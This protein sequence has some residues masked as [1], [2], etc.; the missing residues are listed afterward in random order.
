MEEFQCTCRICGRK[1]P[2]VEKT[3]PTMV[4]S[5]HLIAPEMLCPGS[6]TIS[7]E[8]KYLHLDFERMFEP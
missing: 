1:L 5:P 7:L 6:E 4:V 2:I 3:F 8:E